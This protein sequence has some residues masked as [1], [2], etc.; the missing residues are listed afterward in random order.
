MLFS[1][2]T[3]G[4]TSDPSFTAGSKVN[5]GS[6]TEGNTAAGGAL[7]VGDSG[8]EVVGTSSATACFSSSLGVDASF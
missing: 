8:K 4:D 6:D 7:G 3:G 5:A 2:A 1:V